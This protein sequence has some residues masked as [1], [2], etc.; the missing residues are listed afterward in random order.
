MA[1]W[2]DPVVSRNITDLKLLVDADIGCFQAAASSDGRV[3]KVAR[4]EFKYKKQ[5]LQYCEDYDVSEKLIR[6]EFH[7]EP[8]SHALHNLKAWLQR[9]NDKFPG[10]TLEL[11]LTGKT[12]F[13]NEVYPEYK[14]NRKEERVP[15]HLAECK[16]YL[17]NKHGATI[18]ENCEAD[19][20]IA[21]RSKSLGDKN[22]VVCTLDKDM[23]MIPGKH[24][25]WSKNKEYT[26]SP[27]EGTRAF[28]RQLMTGD[29]TD[30]IPG[31]KG[32]G[33]A[34]AAKVITDDLTDP[35]SMYTKVLKAYCKADPIAKDGDAEEYYTRKIQEVSR[36][37][38]LLWLQR[39]VGEVWQPPVKGETKVSCQDGV[40]TVAY[41][42]YIMSASLCLQETYDKMILKTILGELNAQES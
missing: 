26:V 4:E 20:L 13:R 41:K 8:V 28:Y 42:E 35:H 12:N 38:R 10:A 33:P 21:T 37:A 24:Y 32:T 29:N 34:K 39:E 25:N 23:N 2:D 17:V 15:E 27:E 6:Q 14:D 9:L 3:Y 31:L 7:P 40:D 11:Y 1:E 36:N 30:N 5:A 22:C 18:S 19:D 16:Q